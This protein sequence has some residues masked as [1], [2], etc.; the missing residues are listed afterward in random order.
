[1]YELDDLDIGAE[2][3]KT[4][5]EGRVVPSEFDRVMKERTAK[6]FHLHNRGPRHLSVQLCGSFD[7]WEKRHEMQFDHYANQWF[8]T[9][10]LSRGDYAYKYV[11]DNKQWVINEE[12][13]KKKDQAGNIN[14]YV[15]VQ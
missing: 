11:I 4:P 2:T 10:H 12:E 3:S 9:L 13:T 15:G 6:T 5:F 7:N 1:M 14:N 8:T